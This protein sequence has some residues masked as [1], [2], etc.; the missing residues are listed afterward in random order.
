M[1]GDKYATLSTDPDCGA[2]LG[3]C[4][5]GDGRLRRRAG[6]LEE[7]WRA[8]GP[9]ATGELLLS[10]MRRRTPWSFRPYGEVR[11]GPRGR[12][13]LAT[14]KPGDHIDFG[15]HLGGHADCRPSGGHAPQVKLAN[16]Q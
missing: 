2:R 16:I 13:T 11:T 15:V 9:P 6:G 14:I 3:G 5:R 4:D 12:M 10:K 8:P 7:E 1:K